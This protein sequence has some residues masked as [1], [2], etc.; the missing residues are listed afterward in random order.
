MGGRGDACPPLNF[1]RHLFTPNTQQRLSPP[2]TVTATRSFTLTTPTPAALHAP[3]LV[4]GQG[5]WV[6]APVPSVPEATRAQQAPS[7][8]P[9]PE[10]PR[11]PLCHLLEGQAG[12]AEAGT[13][14]ATCGP[15]VSSGPGAVAL[16]PSWKE[17]GRGWACGGC[18]DSGHLLRDGFRSPVEDVAGQE[19]FHQGQLPLLPAQGV[20]R[21]DHPPETL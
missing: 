17:E 1:T 3:A 2:H 16:R 5:G 14:G 20:Q 10:N 21:V 18:E 4:C 15:G 12:P 13:A 19:P 8:T 9:S 11:C 6:P 7:G